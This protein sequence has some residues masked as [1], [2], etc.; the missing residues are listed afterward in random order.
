MLDL[1]PI[2]YLLGRMSVVVAALMLIPAAVDWRIGNTGN[3]AD[4]L[5]A[6]LIVGTFG[7]LVSLSA[8]NAVGFA[9]DIRQA[10]LLTTAIWLVLPLCGAL[11]LM[12]GAPGLSFT[13]AWF[14]SV[15]GFTTTG[16]TVIVGLDDLPAG[17]NL[18]RGIL[19]WS[20][21]LGIAFVAMIFLPILR[22]GGMQFFRTEGFD[23]FGKVLPRA[24]DIATQ[25]VGVYAVLTVACILTYLALGQTPL[26]A[27]V[28]GMATIATG[29]FSPRDASFTM[30]AGANEYAGALF[31]ILGSLP[32]IRYVQLVN[33]DARP[34]WRD[35]QVRAYLKILGSAVLAVAFW[36][37]ATSDM[38]VE[39][40]F[41]E[42]L[43]NLASIQSSTGFFSGSFGGWGAFMM[44][45]A[46]VIGV[47]GACSGSSAA[48]I[49][50]F[51]ILV[52][53]DA[54]RAHVRRVTMPD[55]MERVKYDGRTVEDDVLNS[56]VMFIAGFILLLGTL[57]LAVTLTG[58]DGESA[59]W[60]VWT[61]I[62]NIGY[63]FGPEI[64]KTGTV[65]TYPDAAKWIFILAM[66]LGRLGLLAILVVVLPRFWRV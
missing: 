29:G 47:I 16:S 56:V 22:V 43:F 41:R 28:H 13:D 31:M 2:A 58:V 23:T 49:G 11:P 37:I 48:G 19:N 12:L 27:T 46:F 32:Y 7:T 14:E 24:N 50:V 10:Y 18:W 20:G 53:W 35:A 25:L 54:L 61:S 62:G 4:F 60:G 40:A 6:A 59:L 44:V 26:D 42:A 15:S 3:A 36:R 51:R 66:L 39:P 55:R 21:G 1:R 5:R 34:V 45:V 30:Y 8:R 63:G 33:G 38:A 65:A 57:T 52:A 17:T 9:L 64:G